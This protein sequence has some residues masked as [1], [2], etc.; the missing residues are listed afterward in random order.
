MRGNRTGL[1][2]LGVGGLLRVATLIALLILPVACAAPAPE[3][4]QAPA[5]EATGAEQVS[6]DTAPPGNQTII[7]A[8]ARAPVS[9]DPA[10]HRS[11]ESETVIR[12]MFD[13]LVTRDTESGVHM[14]LAESIDW[15]DD[16]T[17]EVK[18]RQG[19]KFHDGTE[20]TADDVVFTF[21][22]IIQENMIEYP[23][24]H[25]SP[26]KGLI[27]PL[28]AVE[29][30]D[31][32]T[33]LMHFTD[34]W[35]PALQLL[36]HQQ[37]LPKAYLEEVGT[38]GL[39]NNP[40]GTGPFHFESAQGMDE[41]VLT[42]FED[43]YGGA[44]DLEPA[45]AA[46]V[47]TA[48]FRVIP[49]AS[50][51]VA[52]LLAGEVDIIQEVPAELADTLAQNE[53]IQLKTGPGTR[54]LWMELNVNRAPFDDAK[55]RQALNYAVDK[56]LLAEEL[57]G[58]RA[59]VLPGVLSPYNNYADPDLTP[60]AYDPDMALALL[61][62]AGWNAASEDSILTKDGQ[63][64]AFV[65][66]T[67][68]V[69]RQIAEAVASQLRDIGIDAG[70]RIWEYSVVQPMLLAGERQ[71]YMGDWGDSAFDPVGHME[72]KWHG[73]VEGQPYGRGNFSTYDNPRVNEL[74][75][76]GE[77]E[78]DPEMRKEAYYEA[79]RILYDDA[80]AVFLVLPEVIEAASARVQNWQPAADGR[81]NLH[82][83]C[84]Q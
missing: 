71:A 78:A 84:V 40:I 60:Y 70:V 22:R 8:L 11:R 69:T 37:I 23:Q 67:Q 35:P 41:F 72:A 29:K 19:V 73:F 63:P 2:R 81:V 1:S 53:G 24:P 77:T 59:V 30:Q 76:A 64:F 17:L 33:V 68:E 15:I 58:G 49:E 25:T 38:E 50:T 46:C 26:R 80:P 55:V 39:I 14:E 65:I 7:V 31:D 74:I 28:E 13:G 16:K 12:N 48:V 57:Y 43:Y 21:D 66:D 61:Q 18:L 6:T 5:T 27:A 79:Q 83:V 10:D 54:P 75:V 45:G 20:M 36:V 9:I 51:R 44:P 4:A 47:A 82:D 32:G 62:E 3:A 56:E 52:A 34:T 42:R